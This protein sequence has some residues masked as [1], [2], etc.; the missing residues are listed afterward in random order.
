MDVRRIFVAAA[1]GA[2]F[3]FSDGGIFPDEPPVAVVAVVDALLVEEG[4]KTEAML[5]TSEDPEISITVGTHEFLGKWHT[6]TIARRMCGIGEAHISNLLLDRIRTRTCQQISHNKKIILSYTQQRGSSGNHNSEAS[7][8]SCG[9]MQQAMAQ[10][11]G[12]AIDIAA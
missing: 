6:D 11:L 5:L 12:A 10:C 8:T 9:V 2:D 7:R 3:N 1:G 4:E